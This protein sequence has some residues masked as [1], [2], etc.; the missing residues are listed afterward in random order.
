MEM[1]M[2]RV[3]IVVGLVL[4]AVDGSLASS[5]K[6]FTKRNGWDPSFMNKRQKGLHVCYSLGGG[7]DSGMAFKESSKRN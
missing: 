3:V 5:C 1:N 6:S 2:V 7:T 4:A